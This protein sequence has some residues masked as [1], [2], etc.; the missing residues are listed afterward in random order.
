MS[1]TFP[2]TR[3]P[4]P[5]PKPDPNEL[6]F[7]RQFTDHMFVMDYDE[8]MGWH[9]GRIIPYGDILI[10]PASSVLHYAQMMFEGMKAY[11]TASGEVLLFRP[12]MN[13]RRLNRTN[14]RVCLPQMDEELFVSAVKATVH[15]D[16]DWVPSAPFTSLYIRPFIIADDPALGVRCAC[17][18]RFMIIL[19]PS[20][21]Y[22]AANRGKLSTTR[23][24]VEDEYIRAAQGGTGYAKVGGNYAG[25]L[26]AAQKAYACDCNDV[27]WL[28]A[29]EHKYIEEV[30]SSNAFFVIGDEVVTAP[31][32]GTI[33]PG[34]T[35]DSVLTL[36]REWGVTANE[37]MISIDEVIDAAKKGELKE[38]FAS[39]TAAVISLMGML[40]YQG[41]EYVINNREVGQLSQKIYD[42]IT[43]IQTG[44]LPDTRG[45]TQ[46]VD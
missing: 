36:L 9:D 28:D 12:E 19:C 37:R 18:F 30:G 34:I 42:T 33:L 40:R 5:K 2:V 46:R 39:G 21:P 25:S 31:L 22:Y 44:K 10:S 3:N 35:R 29:F 17:H 8:G 1:Y 41:E 7:G 38:A 20:G 11:K 15:E 27:L 45:W 26:R 23:I 16:F 32:A 14:E 43:G 6:V 4:N 24:F 13:A